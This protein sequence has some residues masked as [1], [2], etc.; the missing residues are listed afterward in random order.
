MW[1]QP[2]IHFES[3]VCEENLVGILHCEPGLIL[4]REK[5]SHI[6]RRCIPE[7]LR[8]QEVGKIV[9]ILIDGLGQGILGVAS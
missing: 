7:H 5:S 9:D 8:E 3:A 4:V 6:F 2:F 1:R